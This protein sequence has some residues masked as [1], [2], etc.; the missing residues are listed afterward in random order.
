MLT[1]NHK[2]PQFTYSARLPW[3]RRL[4]ALA[5]CVG[6]TGILLHLPRLR[7]R[8]LVE[9]RHRHL[10]RRR[11][12]LPAPRLPARR[13]AGRYPPGQPAAV[14]HRGTCPARPPAR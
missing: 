1:T 13:P 9:R 3:R 11:P 7:R 4:R 6:G 12:R 2:Q 8:G 14:A 10:P 5:P